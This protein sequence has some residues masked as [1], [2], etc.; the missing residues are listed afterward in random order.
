MKLLKYLVSCFILMVVTFG[1]G[2]EKENSANV[3]KSNVLNVA[4]DIE[5][6]SL[7]TGVAT[8]GYSFDAI[9]MMIEGLTT[10]DKDGN[11]VLALADSYEVSKDGKTYIFNLKDANWSNG[12]PVTAKDFVFAIKRVAD[13]KT[14]SEY[15]YMVDIAG[16]K[17]A[18]DV[19]TGK[20][21]PDEL[22]VTALSDK[23]LKI[24]LDTPVPYFLSL[25][26]FPT[27]YPINEDFYNQQKGEY[28]LGPDKILANGPFKLQT[29]EQGSGYEVVKNETYYNKDKVKL[30]GINVRVVKDPQAAL[31]A[32]QQ[33]D[34]DC[35]RLNGELVE[36]FMDSPDMMNTLGGFLWY[37]SVNHRV[38]GLDNE[39]MR[40]ALALSYN[41]DQIAKNILKDGSIAANFV[42]PKELSTGVDGKDF[43][44]TAPEYLKTDKEAAKKYYEMAKK[45][46]GQ[47]NF[48]FELLFEDTEAS[49]KVAEFLKS[50]I[51]S[52][53]EGVTITLK[54]VPKKERLALI[55]TGKYDL[56]LTRWGPDYADPT[57]YLELWVT[58]NGSNKAGWQSPEYDKLLYRIQKGDLVQDLAKRWEAMKE[59]E[60][61]LMDQ[62]VIMPVY[63]TGAAELIKPNVTGI[64]HH[65]V[66]VPTD[67]S[68]T[69][70]K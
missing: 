14:G 66:G 7:D 67:Y 36:Q 68:V 50:E 28:G 40:R 46:L 30:D 12:T 15:N 37:I 34:I 32:Y 56:G 48:S 52:N 69:E 25:M 23:K 61:M 24:E 10:T 21:S 35:M 11:V 4:H 33:G 3:S 59:A 63:Q 18:R 29:W 1:C 9:A 49:K 54:Q 53:L 2:Q 17:N 5:L 6:A 41:K 44:D 26:T 27:F 42:V 39:N 51:E 38:K 60:K 58:G 20:K 19:M 13:P 55:R 43:R 22:G 8:D 62:V 47:D 45:E 31:V 57:T 64:I 70:K 65:S 16:I